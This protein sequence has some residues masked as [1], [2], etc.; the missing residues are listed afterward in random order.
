[1]IIYDYIS[2]DQVQ[3]GDQVYVNSDALEDVIR[4]DVGELVVISGYSHNTG[5][6]ESYYL[7]PDDIVEL[8]SV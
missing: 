7:K 1:M 4:Q 5:D 3:D 6:V 8:W 2:A